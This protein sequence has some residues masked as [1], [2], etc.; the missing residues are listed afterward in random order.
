MKKQ[1]LK[2]LVCP[3]CKS[4]I[5]MLRFQNRLE[6]SVETGT[7]QCVKCLKEF[8]IIRYIPRFVP[9]ENYASG[10]GLQWTK[11]ARTQ[12]DS[13]TGASISEARLFDETKWQTNLSGQLVL[14]VGSGSGRFTEQLASTNATIISMDYSFAVEANYTSNGMKDNVFIVQADIYNIP[15]KTNFFDKLLCIGVL[16]HTPN[17]ED[18]FMMLPSFLKSGGK[19]SIDVYLQRTGLKRIFQTKYWVRPI[20]KD[21]PPEK[22]YKYCKLYI[23]FMWPLTKFLNKI[24]YIG[25]KLIRLSLVADYTGK[26]D[27]PNNILKE[28]AL[29]D[30]YDK[31]SPAYDN[32][33]KI[34]TVR[35]WFRVAGMTDVEVHLGYTGVVARAT[36][37]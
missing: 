20:T 12:Y 8:P 13:Y 1:H 34:E 4:D 3:S 32:P 18:A 35:K 33:Q 9:I 2:Y 19:L 36:K 26:Y 31:L 30:T 27:L 37:P 14:E 7:L 16:Q 29:L 5:R 24:Q 25:P 11:H 15:F 23:H 22:L 21:I 17:P 10:F 28:W 6:D